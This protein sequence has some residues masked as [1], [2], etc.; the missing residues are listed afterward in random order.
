MGGLSAPYRGPTEVSYLFIDGAYLSRRLESFGNKWFGRP[1]I[2]NYRAL[3]ANFT[4]VFYYDCLP[5]KKHTETE[6]EF[7]ARRQHIEEHFNELRSLP[8]WHVSEGVAK[9]RKGRGTTQKEVDILIAV[10]ML[11][12]TYRRN[13]H[14]L[15]FIAGDQDFRPLIEAVVRDGM[16]VDLWYEAS[17]ISDELKHAADSTM[18]FDFY[19]F[20]GYLSESFKAAH[21]IPSRHYETGAPPQHGVLIESGSVDGVQVASL[22]KFTNSNHFTII[23]ADKSNGQFLWTTMADDIDFLKRVYT[24]AHGECIWQLK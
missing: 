4:K 23:Q 10:D 24:A 18:E 21:P 11:S 14:R 19:R 8:G 5:S 12:H 13:M 7:A 3:G 2:A 17:S 9:W 15:T 6:A 1:A 20:Y 16:Y 22:W